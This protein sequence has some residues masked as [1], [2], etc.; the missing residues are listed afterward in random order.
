MP[1]QNLLKQTKELYRL[2]TMVLSDS[3]QSLRH[4]PTYLFTETVDNA[5]A[6]L[7]VG[8]G[9][10]ADGFASCILL[11][12]DR[13]GQNK[14]YPGASKW[15]GTLIKDMG[16]EA[17]DIIFV[18]CDEPLNTL[19][20]AEALV[21]YT[22]ARNLHRVIIVAPAFHLVRAFVSMVTA[23][24]CLSTQGLRVHCQVGTALRWDEEAKHSQGTLKRQ[25]SELIMTELDRIVRYQSRRLGSGGLVS[26]DHVFRYLEWRDDE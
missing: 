10:L 26:T 19:S 7:D 18:R 21:Q 1:K 17:K 24:H 12:N 16:V 8:S 3:A 5:Q 15:K 11:L 20:E 14:G 25:R 9:L 22:N 2:A 4:T 23:V 6:V 13:N